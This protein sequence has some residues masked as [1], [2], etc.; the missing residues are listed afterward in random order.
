MKIHTEKRER[1]GKKGLTSKTK[2]PKQEEG[3]NKIK[4]KKWFKTI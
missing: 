3:K 1:N 2:R 4:G